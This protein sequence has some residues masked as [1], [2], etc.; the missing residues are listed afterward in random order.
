[1]LR[2]VKKSME[3]FTKS[4]DASQ[5]SLTAAANHL[6]RASAN[7]RGIQQRMRNLEEMD[8]SEARQ[9]LGDDFPDSEAFQ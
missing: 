9:I 8:M 7:A 3:N 6:E 4:I 5:K 2:A 1:M